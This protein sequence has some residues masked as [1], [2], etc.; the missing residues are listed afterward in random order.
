MRI[1]VKLSRYLSASRHRS[2]VATG[3]IPLAEMHSVVVF[4]DGADPGLEPTKIRIRK[5]FE[6]RSVSF[7]SARDK[8]LRTGSDVFIALNSTPSVDERYAAVWSTARFKIGRH[9]IPGQVYDMVVSDPGEEPSAV[10][11]AFDVMSNL[12][13]HIE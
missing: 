10:S 9:Q 1:L 8:D 13:T 6:G 2:P 3:I 12:I 5:F 7:V 11:S 4:V